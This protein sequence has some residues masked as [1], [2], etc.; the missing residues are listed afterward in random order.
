MLTFGGVNKTKHEMLLGLMLSV[1]G[2]GTRKEKEN[3][4]IMLQEDQYKRRSRSK[5]RGTFGEAAYSS[6]SFTWEAITVWVK[7]RSRAFT[8]KGDRAQ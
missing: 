3:E 6:N 4:N 7:K 5:E 2:H 1:M 8:Q